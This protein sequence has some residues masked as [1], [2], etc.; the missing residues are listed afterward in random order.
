MSEDAA[1]IKAKGIDAFK[2]KDFEKAIEEFAKAIELSPSDHT[3][4]GNTSACYYNLNK[5]DEALES[6]EKCIEVNPGWSKG[7]QRKGMALAALN[8]VPE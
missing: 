5:F 8:K 3:L 7:Y 4:Y 6:A 1:T 2:S